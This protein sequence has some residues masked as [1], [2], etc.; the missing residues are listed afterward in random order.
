MPEIPLSQQL[1]D[2]FCYGSLT[3]GQMADKL[4]DGVTTCNSF[5][6]LSSAI[7]KMISRVSITSQF[8]PSLEAGKSTQI[9]Y[10]NQT[11]KYHINELNLW[12]QL[13][14]GKTS[15]GNKY[16]IWKNP[17]PHSLVSQP[18]VTIA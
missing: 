9:T 3:E 7:T 6:W 14:L 11:S 5:F 2:R 8:R 10:I 18:Q 15:W 12:V 13:L 1:L 4:F 17:F 16:H